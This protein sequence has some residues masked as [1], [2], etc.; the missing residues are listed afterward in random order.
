MHARAK[1]IKQN[2]A[3]G[4]KKENLLLTHNSHL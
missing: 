4:I 2:S 1:L 3:T